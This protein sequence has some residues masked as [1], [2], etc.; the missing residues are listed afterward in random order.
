MDPTLPKDGN[1]DIAKGMQDISISSSTLSSAGGS[2]S[3][4]TV[5]PQVPE[6]KKKEPTAVVDI[7]GLTDAEVI[8]L[9]QEKERKRQLERFARQ[10]AKG[11]DVDREHKFW[12]TQPVPGLKDTFEGESGPM[13][14]NTD[15]SLVKQEPYN[16]PTG[17]E[18]CSLD[19]T[20]PAVILE[21]YTLLSENYVEDD[22]CLF[23]FDYSVP[24]L[25]WALTPPGFLQEWHV[26]V[27]NSKTGYQSRIFEDTFHSCCMRI[28]LS[29]ALLSYERYL[30]FLKSTQI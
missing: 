27:R 11:Q 30:C 14:L 8:H 20:D 26:G 4:A 6:V 28:L 16:M 2:E 10:A 12:S 22:D 29:F 17:F 7:N 3:V 21:V 15:V 24:F 18:W 19:V 13:E 9:L 25:Q 5:V 1:A 23:R